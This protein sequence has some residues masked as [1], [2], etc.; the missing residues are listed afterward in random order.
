MSSIERVILACLPRLLDLRDKH[1]S[2]PTCM[3]SRHSGILF[4]FSGSKGNSANWRLRR[5]REVCGLEKR[6]RTLRSYDPGNG[7]RIAVYDLKLFEDWEVS[8]WLEQI[9]RKRA[10]I[11]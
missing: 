1:A 4:L 2:L 10:R 9:R 3:S 6:R 5:Q 8:I 11:E 7:R